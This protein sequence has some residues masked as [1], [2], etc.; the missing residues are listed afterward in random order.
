MIPV[1]GQ[2]LPPNRTFIVAEIGNNHEGDLGVARD[3]VARAAD[4]GVDAVKFQTFRTAEFVSPQ[5]AERYARMQRFELTFDEF[6]ELADLAHS[7]GLTFLSTPLDHSSAAFLAT[8]ADG[9]KIASGDITHLP[10]IDT[11]ARH[12]LPLV[13]STGLAT[14][15][16]VETAAARAARAK[17]D[18]SVGGEI[19]LLHCVSA[20]PTPDEQANLKAIPAL[21][22]RFAQPIGYS[23][24]TIGSDAAVAAVALGARMIEK[25]FTLDTGYSDFRDHQLSADPAAMAD[26]VNRVRTVEGM[27]GSGE[28]VPQPCEQ[29]SLTAIRRSV[30]VARD[31]GEGEKILP[32]DLIWLRPAE[33]IAPDEADAA[34]GRTARRDLPAGSI[35][36]SDDL[37]DSA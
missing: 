30:A 28:K 20:Y 35:L 23:D 13:L 4:C 31:I 36:H 15:P 10:L 22:A 34:I 26:L 9:L 25:H 29:D 14:M 2:I 33:G 16:E 12:P 18:A 8:I 32:A 21:A 1:T 11:A 37:E 27:L 24:H 6:A 7:L 19:V 3:L 17:S 5:Q